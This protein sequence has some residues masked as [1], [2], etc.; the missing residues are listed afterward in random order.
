MLAGR[1]EHHAV[2]KGSAPP[3]T[4]MAIEL[5]NHISSPMKNGNVEK[6]LVIRNPDARAM[7]HDA[8]MAPTQF[9]VTTSCMGLK[10]TR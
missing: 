7:E 5:D 6:P 2:T 3:R 1:N 10:L 8:A 4:S 9:A